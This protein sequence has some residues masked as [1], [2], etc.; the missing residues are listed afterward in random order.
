MFR[1]KTYT[2]RTDINT[3]LSRSGVPLLAEVCFI[4]W[5]SGDQNGVVFTASIHIHIHMNRIHCIHYIQDLRSLLHQN[6]K[7]WRPECAALHGLCA[8]LLEVDCI[9]MH[10]L[11]SLKF[12]Y[13]LPALHKFPHFCQSNCHVSIPAC[14]V[15]PFLG[16]ESIKDW[17][18]GWG[19]QFSELYH[20]SA[21]KLMWFIRFPHI[22]S[23]FLTGWFH[24]FSANFGS[25]VQTGQLTKSFIE[26]F[27]VR[28]NADPE[29]RTH[30][31]SRILVRRDWKSG[32]EMQR[33][34]RDG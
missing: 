1:Y 24:V 12:M 17:S 22:F 30:A 26:M 33:W 28:C 29:K 15:V 5:S 14:L 21:I 4:L 7:I 34:W 20:N 8:V 6:G 19:Y 2:L 31:A 23:Q 11:S 9:D 25:G 18:P 3:T 10:L 27:R 32:G 16:P 13:L